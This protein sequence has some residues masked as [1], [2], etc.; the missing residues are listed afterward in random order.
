MEGDPPIHPFTSYPPQTLQLDVA[1][2]LLVGPLPELLTRHRPGLR[3][4]ASL[5]PHPPIHRLCLLRLRGVLRGGLRC[6]MAASTQSRNVST[7]SEGIDA[8]RQRA[9]SRWRDRT[10]M[11]YCQLASWLLCQLRN[12]VDYIVGDSSHFLRG[13]HPF[14][15]LYALYHGL[16]EVRGTQPQGPPSVSDYLGV[17]SE[18]PP[19]IR[20]ATT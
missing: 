4:S 1:L 2:V 10:W 5:P 3:S 7:S 16:E 9:P 14:S 13:R 8:M 18:P 11:D 15:G 19:I 17:I 20:V 6:F 12:H